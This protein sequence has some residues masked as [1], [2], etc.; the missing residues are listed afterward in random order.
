MTML[1][2]SAVTSSSIGQD[3][4]FQGSGGVTLAGTLVLPEAVYSNALVPAMLL[5]QGSG[6]TDRDGNQPPDLQADLLRQLA[7][8][9]ADAGIATLRYDKRG[10][11]ANQSTLPKR[12]DE[13][14]DFFSWSAFVHDAHAAF[15]FLVYHPSIAS[16]RVGVLGHSEGGLVALDLATQYRPQP[17]AIVLASTP[18]R[19]LGELIYDQLS[20]LL[21]RQQASAEERQFILAAD[22]RIRSEILEAGKVPPDVP[23]GLAPLYPD[24]LGRFLKSLLALDPVA[25]TNNVDGPILVINGAADTQVSATKDGTRFR[26]AL[27]NR[28]DGSAIFIASAV[29]HNLKGVADTNDPGMAGMIDETVRGTIARWLKMVL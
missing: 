8:M 23:A 9:L 12:P 4:S 1:F 21:I 22:G 16:D 11:Y 18:G 15:T 7:D 10:M 20:A 29:N 14:P 28:Q 17:K 6:P 19:A 25:L 2:N 24:Y 27:A 26:S 3:V 5:I 13:L